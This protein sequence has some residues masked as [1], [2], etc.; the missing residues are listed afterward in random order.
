MRDGRQKGTRAE[1]GERRSR[2][3][4]GGATDGFAWCLRFCVRGG[5]GGSNHL[6]LEKEAVRRA[7]G[8]RMS[9]PGT[10]TH[11]GRGWSRP[12][13]TSAVHMCAGPVLSRTSADRLPLF[14]GVHSSGPVEDLFSLCFMPHLRTGRPETAGDDVEASVLHI[15]EGGGGQNTATSLCPSLLSSQLLLF[16]RPECR[17]DPRAPNKRTK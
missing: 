5:G 13:H 9:A 1:D 3:D 16:Q 8:T 11:T 10:H 2:E 7:S 12:A 14:P 4:G 15:Q 6:S 17:L